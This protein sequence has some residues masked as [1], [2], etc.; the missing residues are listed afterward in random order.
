MT[1]VAITYAGAEY[2]DRMRALQFGFVKPEGVDLTYLAT[3]AR[4][5]VFIWSSTMLGI[6]SAG[7]V[8]SGRMPILWRGGESHG[9]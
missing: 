6:G 4:C 3:G 1:E 9:C 5:T 2:L 7:V 8:A